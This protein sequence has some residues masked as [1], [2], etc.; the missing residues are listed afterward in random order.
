[1]STDPSPQGKLILYNVCIGALLDENAHEFS[2]NQAQL[3]LS[4]I[5]DIIRFPKYA[6]S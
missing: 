6:S 5:T 2:S 3:F 4:E 1:M